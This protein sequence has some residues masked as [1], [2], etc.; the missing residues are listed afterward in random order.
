M[1]T[2]YRVGDIVLVRPFCNP[3]GL[4]GVIEEIK[5]LNQYES[6]DEGLDNWVYI[7]KYLANKDNFQRTHIHVSIYEPNGISQKFNNINVAKVLYGKK[8]D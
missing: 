8:E 2:K 5:C 7:V 6:P 1:R 4:I 3:C